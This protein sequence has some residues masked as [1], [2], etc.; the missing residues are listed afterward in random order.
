MDTWATS[1]LTPQIACG[2]E[3]DTDLFE[4][5]FP[6]DLCTQAHDIIRTW[7]FSR[8]VRAHH[9][10]HVVPW[11]HALV[12]GFVVDPDR[13]K[14]SKSK[15]NVVVP[16][17]ILDKYGADAVRW[18]AAMARPGL[19]SP[20][21]ESQMKVGRRLAMKVLNASRFV[22]DGVGASTVDL[23]AVSEPVDRALLSRLATVVTD[24]TDAF[25]AYDYTTA[26]ERIEKSFWEFCDDYLELVKERAYDEQGGP[27]TASAKAALATALHVQ[28]RL[29]APFLPYVT[30]EVWSWWQEGSVHLASWPTAGELT[31]AA[32]GDAAMLDAVAAALAGIRGA[33]SQ[34]KV[35]MRAELS[36]VEVFGPAALVD[37]ARSAED[38]LRKV[39]KIT[40][41][42]L[43]T[44]R[45]DA[46][47]LTVVAE[48]A[49]QE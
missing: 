21:D 42:L 30:E 45:P 1:S 22:L 16:T 29:L 44:P 15:G 35:S 5:T 31:D 23:G 7:L 18:R 12:S 19:D 8:V 38:D 2:W 48:L 3:T 4:R 28:L 13:K 37:A 33:K 49:T 17:E 11:S 10:N 43:F 41:E 14:M 20:F 40:G 26:L 34:A 25:D 9:E 6:M 36:R 24:A 46:T 39:G 27:A 47:E 32:R